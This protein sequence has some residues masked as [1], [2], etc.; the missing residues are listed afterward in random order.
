MKLNPFKV[1]VLELVFLGI[2]VGFIPNL[3]HAGLTR[4]MLPCT[5][6]SE[7]CHQIMVF[8]LVELSISVVFAAIAIVIAIYLS[9]EYN[10]TS[11]Q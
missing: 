11:S 1:L 3:V 6:S 8:G 4:L 7:V 10:K 9:A 5:E 2:V